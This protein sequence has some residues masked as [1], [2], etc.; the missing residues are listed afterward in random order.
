MTIGSVLASSLLLLL[1]Y[2]C[3][4]ST[5]GPTGTSYER[6]TSEQLELPWERSRLNVWFAQNQAPASVTFQAHTDTARVV[7][8]EL[9]LLATNLDVQNTDGGV[10]HGGYTPHPA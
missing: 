10:G 8:I 7:L 9:T 4:I 2:G 6:T 1:L 5:C 3:E